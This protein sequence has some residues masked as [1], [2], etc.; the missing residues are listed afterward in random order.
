MRLLDQ[1]AQCSDPCWVQAPDGERPI[2]LPG[3]NDYATRVAGC[4]LRYVL[5]DEVTAMCA[6]LALASGDRLSGCLDLIHLPAPQMWVEWNDAP[7]AQVMQHIFPGKS[8]TNRM[9]LEVSEPAAQLPVRAGV[10]ISAARD[11]RR[12]MLKTFWSDGSGILNLAPAETHLDLES[13]WPATEVGSPF[14]GG[15]MRISAP[16]PG[17]E[18]LL[19]CMRFRIDP[20][21]A[22]YYQRY[23]R[24]PGCRAEV[25]RSTI[26][27][28]ACD[29]PV[30]LAFCLMLGANN[31][32][33]SRSVER[34]RLNRSRMRKGKPR[35][36][37]YVEVCCPL[38]PAEHC[39]TH[40]RPA[41]E[42]PSHRRRLHFVRGH[43]VRRHNQ[44]HWRVAHLRGRASLGV[45]KART[46]TL[47][48]PQRQAP[49]T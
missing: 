18:S 13:G 25:L 27:T 39:T 7:R 33:E 6:Q 22:R 19:N 41:N 37:D 34:S 47:S 24:D 32:L 26:A 42:L 1:V 10:L 44:L 15:W 45:V 30:A 17:L 29:M 43:L 20:Q 11:G 5:T 49:A 8:I 40:E 12:G 23:A 31:A 9:S 35:L 36:L 28:V 38:L 14:D 16:D 46:I 48:F 2:R 3:A 21:W 4:P